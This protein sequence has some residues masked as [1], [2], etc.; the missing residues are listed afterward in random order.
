MYLRLPACV[1]LDRQAMLS[2][3][4]ADGGGQVTGFRRQIL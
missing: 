4:I 1:L 3:A 2:G